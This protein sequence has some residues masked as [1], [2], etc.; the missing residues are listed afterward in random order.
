MSLFQII[1]PLI[2][3]RLFLLQLSILQFKS[4][5][6][7]ISQTE[8]IAFSV[9]MDLLISKP[10]YISLQIPK[11]PRIISS[12]IYRT[13]FRIHQQDLLQSTTHSS[14]RVAPAGNFPR[15]F[16]RNPCKTQSQ[17]HNTTFLVCPSCTFSLNSAEM[18]YRELFRQTGCSG[19]VLRYRGPSF[20]SCGFSPLRL[21]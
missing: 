6:W 18:S 2:C 11:I 12:N 7:I 21:H 17:L 8:K 5:Y 14:N 9:V 15:N 19:F 13:E 4:C 16:I 3:L 1:A 20:K 10:S